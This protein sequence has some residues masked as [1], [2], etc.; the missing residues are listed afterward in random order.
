[1]AEASPPPSPRPLHPWMR[2]ILYA[3]SLLVFLAGFQLFVLTEQTATYFAWTVLPPITAS[4]LGAAYWA[5]VPVEFLAARQRT[6][7]RARV[8]VPGVWTFTTLTLIV[9]L[10]HVDRFHFSS[11][12]PAPRAAAW[13]WLGIYAGVPAAMLLVGHLQWRRPGGEPPRE[14]PLPLWLRL[15]FAGEGG[16]LAVAG[17]AFLLVPAI[18][19]PAWPWTLTALTARAIGAW[20]VGLSVVSLHAFREGDFLRIR[21]VG[22]GLAVFGVLELVSLARYPGEVAW[23][24][25]GAWLYLVFLVSLLPVGLWALL[26]PRSAVPRNP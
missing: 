2:W 10:V 1:M 4:S 22:G 26:G 15:Y 9:T 14:R 16:A 5:A 6:W 17:S 21:P 20:F 19:S 8:A 18:A 25:A 3:A 13:L 11:P 12:D 24:T 23:G 7:A